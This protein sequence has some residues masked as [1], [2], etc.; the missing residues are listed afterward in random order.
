MILIKSILLTGI[1]FA[2]QKNIATAI[3]EDVIDIIKLG[4]EVTEG[5]L[6]TWE[7]VDQTHLIS[8]GVDYPFFKKQQKKI[9]N[10]MNELSRQIDYAEAEVNLYKSFKNFRVLH[11]FIVYEIKYI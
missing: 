2:A 6:E 7:L 3:I 10:R 11:Y 4:K 9:L 1:I 8:G 5:V